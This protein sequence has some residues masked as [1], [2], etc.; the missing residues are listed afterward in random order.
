MEI[1]IV[2]GSTLYADK[3]YTNYEL[4]DLL[5]EAVDIRLVPQR[6]ACMKRQHYGPLAYLQTIQRKQIETTFSQITRLFPRSITAAT[7]R[8]FIMKILLF[9]IAYVFLIAFRDRAL[10][11]SC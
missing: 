9:V 8:G 4:E 5:R 2:P 11:K 6:K 7:K 3:A 10:A 1:D